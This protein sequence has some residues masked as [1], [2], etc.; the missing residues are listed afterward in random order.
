MTLFHELEQFRREFLAKF[1]KDKAALMA[2]ADE[3]LAERDI[4][5]LALKTGDFAP[6]FTLADAT[7]KN[8]SLHQTLA[9]G[10][11][12]LTF[13]RGGWCPYCN[14]E[15]RAYQRALPDIRNAGAQLMA[16]SPQSP[17]A[18]LTTQ[19]KNALTFSVLSDINGDVARAF[20]I[21]FTLPD[22]LADLYAKLGNNLT[23]INASG[24]SELPIPATYVIGQDG[25]IISHHVQIDYR[26][27]MEPS[28]AIKA[29]AESG[30]LA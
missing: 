25:R 2:Q 3:E 1:P 23:R 6:D 7:G 10:P 17:D 18:S 20:G 13:Y 30:V 19:E 21:L 27:R 22:Y 26:T 15:L 9:H 29:L 12:I 14:L 16:V 24:R 8:I 5:R 4:T 28:D 11:V